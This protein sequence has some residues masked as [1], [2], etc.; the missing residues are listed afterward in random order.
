MRFD[1][2][3]SARLDKQYATQTI[4]EQRRRTLEALALKPGE[5]ALD[6]GCGPGYLT[7]E[8]ALSVGATGHV[9]G[10][11]LS[12]AM[13]EIA[14]RR[15]ADLPWVRLHEADAHRIPLADASMDA[16]ASVQV[17]LFARNLAPVLAEL[18][19]VLRPG[20]RAVIVDTDWDSVVWH[21]SDHARMERFLAVWK[22]RYTNARVA[23]LFPGALRRAGFRIE[24]ATA[25]PIVE[26][27]CDEGSYSA[28]TL[29]GLPRFVSGRQGITQDDAQAWTQDQHELNVQGSYFF[30]LNRFLFLARKPA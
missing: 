2:Q 17:Y 20:G 14:R 12:P 9:D 6:V 26:L 23:R 13:L 16:T 7:L 21:S 19:R 3:E 29:K 24:S 10:I 28:S 18:Y 4:V 22:Q 30:A 5:A 8:M 15:C 1:A 27:A 11:D 25:I